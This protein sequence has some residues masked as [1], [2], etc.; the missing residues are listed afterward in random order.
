MGGGRGT[1]VS[2]ARGRASR[3]EK[4]PFELLPEPVQLRDAK[5]DSDI[6]IRIRSGDK[7]QVHAQNNLP[8]SSYHPAY[9]EFYSFIKF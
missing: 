1:I 7:E 2:S 5:S 9:S 6:R 3:T 4:M 8:S